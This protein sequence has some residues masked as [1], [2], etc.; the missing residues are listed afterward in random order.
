MVWYQLTAFVGYRVQVSMSN[1]FLLDLHGVASADCI[2]VGFRV[3]VSMSY[4]FLLHL[5]GLESADCLLI[6]VILYKCP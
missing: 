6:L 4:Q 1:P 2:F 3:Q 5:Y